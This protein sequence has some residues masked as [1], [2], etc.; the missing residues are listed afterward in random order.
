[1]IRYNSE[2]KFLKLVLLLCLLFFVFSFTFSTSQDFNQDLGRHLKLGEIISKT[3]SVPN[4]NLFS[5]TYPG[6]PFI[7]H[8]WMSEIIFYNLVRFFGL[9]SLIYLKI[10]LITLSVLIILKSTT[11]RATYISG[12]I[13]ALLFSPLLVERAD[14]RPEIFAYFLFSWLLLIVV[15]YQKNSRKIYFIPL[16]IVLWINL[17][18]SF[19]FGILLIILLAI[20]MLVMKDRKIK[21]WFFIFFGFLVLFFN[22]NF[23]KGI[24]YPL[25]IFQNYG[26]PIVENQNL[27]L[28]N[29]LTFNPL[30]KYFFL[31][32]PIVIVSFIVVLLT[33][34]FIEAI[35]LLIFFCLAIWQ[36]RHFPFFVFAAIPTV[37]KALNYIETSFIKWVCEFR[38]RNE[39]RPHILK[40]I[41]LILL[42]FMYLFLAWFFISNRYY[43]VFD[44][45]K[46]FGFGYEE[47][48]K[49]AVEFLQ[50]NN[51]AKNIYSNFDIGGYLIYKLY[52][53]YQLFVD[54]RPEAYPAEFLHR[55]GITLLQNPQNLDNLFQKYQIHTIFFAHT[56]ETSWGQFFLKRI[57][58]QN[59]WKL[60]FLDSSVVIFSK[61]TVL[62]D[63]RN[64]QIYLKNRIDNENNYLSLLRLTRILS[65][66]QNN[67]LAQKAL[68]KAATNN[69][70][71]CVIRRYE[72]Q[73]LADSINFTDAE[74][75]K[76]KN[77]WCF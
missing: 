8:H 29:T 40:F 48:A 57:L 52:P 4:I 44:I 38:G 7:N 67:D 25:T 22:P 27:F 28:L 33:G 21:N 11:N 65:L 64:S 12:V 51:L 35:I 5:Y 39:H 14:I 76:N 10:A 75:L 56:D 13:S 58:Q 68:K 71:S 50:K 1:M 31:L 70:Y 19:I 9:S 36:I 59:T 47:N 72:Y 66:T 26:Y 42:C 63:I 32:S 2:M 23:L 49:P 16:I 37:A 53:K 3:K 54:N 17:H 45:D 74:E 15:T 24:L 77:W 20:K 34:Q 46:S 41:I 6:F 61:N 55:T 69:L 30:I 43:Q 73:L 60:V 18:I 62:P